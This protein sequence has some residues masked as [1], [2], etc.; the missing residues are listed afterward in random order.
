MDDILYGEERKQDE[1][2]HCLKESEFAVRILNQ[3][4]HFGLYGESVHLSCYAMDCPAG[5]IVFEE[6]LEF[7]DFCL[8]LLMVKVSYVYLIFYQ[9]SD[10][11]LSNTLAIL[12]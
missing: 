3:T 5:I 2:L 6:T 8:L 11:E 10:N 9:Y 7:S 12:F 4:D 1:Q